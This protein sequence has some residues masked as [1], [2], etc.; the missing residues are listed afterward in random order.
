M[1]A[2]PFDV[3]YDG[4]NAEG[5]HEF[6]SHALVVHMTDENIEALRTHPE[7]NGL[8]GMVDEA[9]HRAAASGQA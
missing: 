9:T 1:H 7:L 2:Q 3:Q 6:R 4:R 8:A 5:L